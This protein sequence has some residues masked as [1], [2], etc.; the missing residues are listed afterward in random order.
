MPSGVVDIEEDYGRGYGG[1]K[2]VRILKEEGIADLFPGIIP[3][4][5]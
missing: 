1:E 3:T 5:T 2:L 4:E